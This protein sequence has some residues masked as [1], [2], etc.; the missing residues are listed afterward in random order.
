[1]ANRNFSSNKLYQFESYGVLLSCNF[2]VDHANNNGLGIRSLKGEGI[3]NVFMHTVPAATVFSATFASG[4]NLLTTNAAAMLNLYVGQT[5]TDTSTSGNIASGSTITALN[6]L[7]NVVTISKNTLGASATLGDTMSAVFTA[8]G[9]NAGATNPNPNSGIIMLQTADTY[10]RLLQAHT[11]IISPVGTP[12]T[13]TVAGSLEL[14]TTLGTATLAQW[15]AVGLPVGV[16]PAVGVSFIPTSTAT[17]GG[18]AT[19]APASTSGITC[20][21]G[22]G[23]ASS[24]NAVN[25][26]LPASQGMYVY[27]QTLAATSSS[28]TTLIPTAPADGSVIAIDLYLS[29]SSVA[30]KGQ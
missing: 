8:G 16:T 12:S 29:N 27:F 15:Q 9:L 21:E 13:A 7:T 2:V 11:S 19:V 20:V 10:Q 25:P 30:V 1:M 5:V 6:P 23:D 24:N 17:I 18:S 4:S 22:Y 14:I 28:T 26:A 3:R